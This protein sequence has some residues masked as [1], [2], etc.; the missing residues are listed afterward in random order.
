MFH[1]YSYLLRSFWLFRVFLSAKYARDFDRDCLEFVD[2]FVCYLYLSNIRIFQLIN[3]EMEVSFHLFV[4]SLISF[5]AVQFL[6]YKSFATF[7][8]LFL[9]IF[10]HFDAILNGIVFPFRMKSESES[11]SVVFESL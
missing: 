10:S 4:L 7:V 2:S 6:V 1:F 9:N 11:C 3:V 5:Q 8:N